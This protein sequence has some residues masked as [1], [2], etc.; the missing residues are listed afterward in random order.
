MIEEK[1]RPT[2]KA[3]LEKLDERF[4]FDIAAEWDNVG[5]LTGHSRAG[6][7][8]VLVTLD[9]V[10]RVVELAIESGVDLIVSHHPPF[11]NPMKK[12]NDSTPEGELVLRL[13]EERISLISAHTN[14]DLS[15]EGVSTWLA[16]R[17]GASSVYPLKEVGEERKFKLVVFT[18]KDSVDKVLNAAFSAGAGVIGNYSRCSFRS[19]GT[20]TFYPE[21]KASPKVGVK[22]VFQEVDEERVEVV[23]PGSVLQDVISRVREAH[24][25]EEAAIDVYPLED[26][27]FKGWL[28]VRFDVDPPEKLRDFLE[29]TLRWVNPINLRYA[30]D[31]DRRIGK[32]AVLAGSGGNF[33]N[34]IVKTDVDLFVS[35][36]LKHHQV[37]ALVEAGKAVVDLGHYDSEKYFVQEVGDFLEEE[38]GETLSVMRYEES[39]EYVRTWIRNKE[40]EI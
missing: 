40:S 39:T 13:C 26:G 36:D 35:G 17:L 15:P 32:V 33:V 9:V 30:G 25:Y 20:G 3:I 29:K 34:E 2:V 18:P 23:V 21:E 1:T 5:L 24:P 11:L 7:S 8:K 14:A 12:V 28:G 37:H 31:L 16:R 4:P 38:F 10:S 6:V 27:V 19:P 22:G